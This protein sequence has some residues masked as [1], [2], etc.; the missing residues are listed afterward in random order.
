MHDITPFELWREWYVAEDDKQSPFYGES[1][2]RINFQHK[3]YNYYIH[4]EWEDIGSNTLY[5]K[6]LF[7]EYDNHTAII[8]LIGEWNDCLYN[9]I[10]ILKRDFIDI[11][12]SSGINRF[13]LL[14][15]NVMTFYASDDCYYEEWYDDIKDN[16]G[17]I[18]LIGLRPHVKDE[19]DSIA[20]FNYLHLND[21][22]NDI[23]WQRLKPQGLCE[24]VEKM[25]VK[26]IS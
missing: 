12:I 24:L 15:E 8:E 26:P 22:L 11:L 4:P 13:I 16:G 6:V 3:V 17:W 18:A 7:V 25:I 20:L 1:A 23:Q 2:D 14:C 19:M 5:L 9:D 21:E 10:M